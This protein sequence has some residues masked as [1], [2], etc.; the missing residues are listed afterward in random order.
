MSLYLNFEGGGL[1]FEQMYH[2]N[3]QG[4]VLGRLTG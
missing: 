2:M 4:C 1:S 3:N